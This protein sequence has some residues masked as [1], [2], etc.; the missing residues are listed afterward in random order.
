M[1]IEE[2]TNKAN[3]RLQS[4]GLGAERREEIQI[5]SISAGSQ[6]RLDLD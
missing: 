6:P 1:L 5:V 4:T 2:Q 3:Q